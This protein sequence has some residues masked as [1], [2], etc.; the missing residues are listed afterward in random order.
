MLGGAVS[1]ALLSPQQSG[2]RG[3][4]A[5]AGAVRGTAGFTVTAPVGLHGGST[6]KF[7]SIDQSIDQ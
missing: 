5:A 2:A 4:D 3:S 1:S 6:G 7:L